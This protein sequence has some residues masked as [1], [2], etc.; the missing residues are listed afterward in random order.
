MARFCTKLA[1]EKKKVQTWDISDPLPTTPKLKL[2][3]VQQKGLEKEESVKV[4]DES[5]DQ[6][7]QQSKQEVLEMLG[8]IQEKIHQ[9]GKAQAGDASNWGHAGDLG[10]VKE[11]LQEVLAFLGE[12]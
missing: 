10:H 4:A 7:Y 12:G 2:P 8:R 9:H 6:A 11:V 1:E 3:P 5:A